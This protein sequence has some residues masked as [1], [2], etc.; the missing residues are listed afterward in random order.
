MSEDWRL[1]GQ[2]AYL[3]GAVLVRRRW[4]QSRPH[5]DHEHCEFCG[6]KFGEA[7]DDIREGWTTEGEYRWICDGCFNDF[8]E[9]FRWR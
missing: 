1:Q 7:P 5:W 2:Q 6:A 9:R 8:R 3:T 4:E